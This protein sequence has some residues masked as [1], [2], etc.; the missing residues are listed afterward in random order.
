MKKKLRIIVMSLFVS[1]CF[2][3]AAVSNGSSEEYTAL[4]GLKSAKAVFDFKIGKPNSAAA[5]LKLIHKTF[6][7]KSITDLAN[8]PDFVVVF[9]GLSAKI[10]SKNRGE[11][12]PEEHKILDEIASII[13]EM[14]KD[15]IKMEI[16]LYAAKALGVDYASILKEI[17]HVGNGWV[18]LIGYQAN[19][20]SL[21]PA[22]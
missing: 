7:D 2:L 1:I 9:I 11:F 21:V 12:S 20:Y 14:S 15:G 4:K 6:K 3:L 19:G 13:S 16:C 10:V 8:K 18:S 22:Y 17:T 5:H